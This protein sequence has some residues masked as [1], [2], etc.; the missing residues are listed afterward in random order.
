M[1]RFDPNNNWYIVNLNGS[2][3][4]SNVTLRIRYIGNNYIE[5]VVVKNNN[6]TYTNV[7]GRA[8]DGWSQV[9]VNCPDKGL[10]LELFSGGRKI[11]AAIHVD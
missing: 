8:T 4:G 5:R 10:V 2:R 3:S 9:T 11:E 7:S 1:G 6:T